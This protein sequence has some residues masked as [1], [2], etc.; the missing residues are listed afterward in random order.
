LVPIR[1][2]GVR[3][4]SDFY[5]AVDDV[6]NP[7]N[8]SRPSPSQTSQI[9]GRRALALSLLDLCFFEF[10]AIVFLDD[11]LLGAG[12]RIFLRD[13]ENARSGTAQK[14]DFLRG[15]FGHG[16]LISVLWGFAAI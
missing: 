15:W 11:D 10:N 14:L 2:A 4:S 1:Q 5:P 13:V 16:R 7:A 6:T 3:D 12:A 8:S 9:S